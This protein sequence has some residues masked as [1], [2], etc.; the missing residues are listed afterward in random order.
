MRNGDPTGEPVGLIF[1]EFF[2]L[3]EVVHAAK[4]RAD[5]HEKHFSEVMLL[6]IAAAWVFDDLKGFKVLGKA[7]TIVD[8]VRVSRHPS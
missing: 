1:A 7:D 5:D 4:S 2:D 8:F 6:V 3:G